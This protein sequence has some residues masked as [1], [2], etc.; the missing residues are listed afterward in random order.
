MSV[1][2]TGERGLDG[3]PFNVGD[4]VMVRCLVN[5]I[6]PAGG[7]GSR[8]NLTVDAPGNIGEAIGVTFNVSPTQCRR[9]QGTTNSQP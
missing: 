6:V 5:S 4:F 9:S 2:F 3:S 8:V 7:A 1:T